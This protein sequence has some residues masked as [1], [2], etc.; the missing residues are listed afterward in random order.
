MKNGVIVA[1]QPEAAEAGADVLARGGNAIDAALACA[2]V[3]GAVDPQMSG[4]GGF[5][6]MQVYMPKKGVHEIVEFYARAP[7]A[8]TPDMW[9]DKLIGQASDG[10][11]YIL[12]GNISEIGYLAVCTPGSV[13]GYAHAM[14]H[15]GTFDWADLI[16][17]AIDYARKGFMVRPHVHWYW[18]QD[19][20]KAHL[21]NTRDKLAFSETGREVYFRPDGGLKEIGDIVVNPDM[22]NTLE[23]LA[24]AGPDAFYRGE[25]AEQIA[26]DFARNGGLISHRDL[27]EYQLSV[28]QPLWG[29]YR[30]HRISTSPPPGSGLPMLQLL[31]I[32]ENF[33]M[34]RMEHGSYDHVRILAEAI[35]RMTVD[36]DRYMGDPHYVDVP[37]ERILSK[38]YCRELAREIIDG[39]RAAVNRLD[40]SQRDTTHISVV[41]KEGNAVAMTHTLGSPSGAITKGL[42][43]MYNGTMS[44]FDPRPG[45]AASIAPGK[46][47]AS[48]AAPSIVFKDDRPYVVLGAPGGSH[49]APS[50]A[51]GL[52]NVLDFDMSMLEAVSAPR[53]SAVSNAIDVSNRIR[54]SVTDRLEAE[55]YDVN[56]SPQGYA[57]AALH[58]VRI[59][60]DVCEGAADPQRDGCA[61]SVS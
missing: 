24:H 26:D 37:V 51:Q 55:G 29:E 20:S 23:R 7:L 59:D 3:Q 1:A 46:R 60:D 13:K 15:Y 31:H 5:G 43:F 57:F 38:S 18:S 44:R 56:R 47:R 35:K 53:I 34:G 49:I 16:R 58:G 54:R 32:M 45:R 28:T 30:G 25:I 11:G 9:V 61:Y 52:M 8:A 6:S 33:D 27:A 14:E 41:D 19:Q 48:S 12:Q 42:G 17:P 50:V 4:I 10:F 2:F 36:K 22:A 21:S 39:K 40:M